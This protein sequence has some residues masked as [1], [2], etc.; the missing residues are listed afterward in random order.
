MLYKMSNYSAAKFS[1]E[2]RGGSLPLQVGKSFDEAAATPTFCQNLEC[3]QQF[4]ERKGFPGS[5]QLSIE[6]LWIYTRRRFLSLSLSL[7]LSRSPFFP[8]NLDSNCSAHY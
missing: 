1:I 8:A 7:S 6:F 2:R 3:R 5:E 4:P